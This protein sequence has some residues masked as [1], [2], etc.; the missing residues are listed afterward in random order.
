MWL[1]SGI[2]WS[3]SRVFS[4]P[5]SDEALLRINVNGREPMGIVN[6]GAEFDEIVQRLRHEFGQLV[7]PLN[8]QQ[9]VAD[10]L[11]VDTTCP[12]PLRRDLPDV[13]AKW[14]MEARVGAD[15]DSPSFGRLHGCGGHEV[16]PF[17]TGN[18]RNVAFAAMRGPSL[19]ENIYKEE[20]H[21]IDVAPTLLSLLGVDPPPHFEGRAWL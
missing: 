11:S 7:N 6:A 8:G 3:R 10:V 16:P 21:I 15:L 2:D 20:G 12:G 9:A 4:I 14:N 5:S 17:Y 18:H 1:N 19:P 13:V